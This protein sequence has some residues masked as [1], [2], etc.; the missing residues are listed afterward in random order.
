VPRNLFVV[1]GLAAAAGLGALLP[2]AFG[3]TEVAPTI[4][5]NALAQTSRVQGA[6]ERTLVL[7]RVVVKP[8]AQLA[9]HHHEGTQVAHIQAGVLTYTV[10]RGAVV[11]RR[12]ESDQKSHV[13]RRIA[14]DQTG[15]IRAGEWIVEQPA[16]IHRA[17]NRGSAPVVIYLATLLKQGAPPATPVASPTGS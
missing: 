17:A 9:L 1:F 6:P 10:R 13:V 3:Q 4:V 14:A 7:S 11:V 2:G 12:G 8:G 5:R 15:P 16:T